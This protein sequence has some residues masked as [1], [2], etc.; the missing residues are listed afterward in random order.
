[1]NVIFLQEYETGK[2]TSPPF[3]NDYLEWTILNV[4]NPLVEKK[5]S[6]YN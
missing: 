1:M 3:L 2:T 5:Y 6:D 4:V